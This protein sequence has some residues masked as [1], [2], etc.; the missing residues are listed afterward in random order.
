MQNRMSCVSA[1]G[2]GLISIIGFCGLGEIALGEDARNICPEIELRLEQDRSLAIAGYPL[3]ISGRLKNVSRSAVAIDTG[4]DG[5]LPDSSLGHSGE[6]GASAFRLTLTKPGGAIFE[7]TPFTGQGINVAGIF[8][9]RT[10]QSV[11]FSLTPASYFGLLPSGQYKISL[12]F[13][14]FPGSNGCAWP[15]AE[16]EFKVGEEF[17]SRIL[18]DA[19]RWVYLSVRGTR[20]ERMAAAQLLPSVASQGGLGAIVE[21]LQTARDREVLLA[22]V[23]ALM[24][25]GSVESLALLAEL[26]CSRGGFLEAEITAAIRELSDRGQSDE[27]KDQARRLTRAMMPCADGD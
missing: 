23:R 27:V 1:V 5:R 26:R 19:Q 15:H 6:L 17:E 4:R 3:I 16:I 24:S 18:A 14:G 7:A 9:L 13:R 12:E 20:V 21:I 11:P 25:T 8:E 10:G 22:G 2:I